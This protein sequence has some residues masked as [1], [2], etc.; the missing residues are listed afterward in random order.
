MLPLLGSPNRAFEQADLYFRFLRRIALYLLVHLPDACDHIDLNAGGNIRE[1]LGC[2]SAE[3]NEAGDHQ[4]E[5]RRTLL[6]FDS[7]DNFRTL[8]S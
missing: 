5:R 4:P 7:R 3:K 2:R 6:P 1:Q 8:P